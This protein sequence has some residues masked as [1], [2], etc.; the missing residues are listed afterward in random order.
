M[1]IVKESLN[2]SVGKIKLKD[3]LNYNAPKNLK[4]ISQGYNRDQGHHSVYRLGDIE[5]EAAYEGGNNYKGGEIWLCA[6]NPK[7]HISYE[8]FYRIMQV[9]P[10]I[11]KNIKKKFYII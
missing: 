4:Y 3:F 9:L 11:L 1:K 8:G 7:T 10:K 2:E 6:Y 5:I